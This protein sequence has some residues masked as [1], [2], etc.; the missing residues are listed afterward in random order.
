MYL[1]IL[2]A[3]ELHESADCELAL[4]NFE[5]KKCSISNLFYNELPKWRSL[6]T[7]NIKTISENSMRAFANITLLSCTELSE[8]TKLINS[9]KSLLAY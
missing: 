6:L 5:K 8:Y 9:F 2:V 7:G 1:T 3:E 4:T